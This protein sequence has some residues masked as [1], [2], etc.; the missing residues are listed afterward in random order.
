MQLRR[1]VYLEW[2]PGEKDGGKDERV[3]EER[4][5]RK[6]PWLGRS[7]LPHFVDLVLRVPTKL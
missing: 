6:P 4:K 5:Q 1:N 2:E 7:V 3:G